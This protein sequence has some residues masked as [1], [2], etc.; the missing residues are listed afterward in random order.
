[1]MTYYAI[2][3]LVVSLL[4]KLIVEWLSNRPSNHKVYSVE[5]IEQELEAAFVERESVELWTTQEY[6]PLLLDKIKLVLDSGFPDSQIAALVHRVSTQRIRNYRS[7]VFP[8]RVDGVSSDM[9]LQ[10]LS[11]DKE[12][13]NMLITADPRIVE[14]VKNEAANLPGTA[15][16]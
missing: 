8:I 1:M 14:V 2:G 3:F 13:I 9:E 6:F 5:E 4:G 16:A 11:P 15:V 10:W 12:R 7:A